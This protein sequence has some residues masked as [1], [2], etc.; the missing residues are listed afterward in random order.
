VR[1]ILIYK[2]VDEAI[3]PTD[4]IEAGC[5]VDVVEPTPE[6]RAWMLE[7]LHVVPEFVRSA[8]DDEETAHT[9]F[10]DD[11]GQSLI[12]IDCPFVEDEN[13]AVDSTV[14]QY[15]TQPITFIFMPDREFFLTVN[16][17]RND[18][19]RAF[20]HGRERRA[21]TTWRTQFFLQVLL[22]V[23]QS[24]L[25]CLHN[26]NRQLREFE[27]TM[28]ET[29]RNRELMRMLGLEKSLIYLSTSLKGLEATAT[30]V[31]G[32]RVVPLREEDKDLLEDVMIEIR[33][34]IEMSTIYTNILNGITDTFS[35]IISNN[36]NITMRTL[37][38]IT[39]VLAI[40]T[41][42]FSFYGMN[43]EGLPFI[44]NWY[45]AVALAAVLCA[46]TIII[47]KCSRFLR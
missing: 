27:R 24:Y 42:V 30:R 40:P 47:L 20:A 44:E 29:M 8:L 7:E 22:R 4:T 23:A 15:D 1:M 41:I 2:M 3:T 17:R 33:Q 45:F 46:L 38:I 28:R 12:T 18:V 21:D 13:E 31:G 37:T 11:T 10:D 6:E 5:W 9:D 43:V 16:L 25:A 32:G 35:S 34:A 39:L 14:V 26:I 36:L 19:I